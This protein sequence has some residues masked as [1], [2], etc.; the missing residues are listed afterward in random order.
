MRHNA[1]ASNQRLMSSESLVEADL[2]VKAIL[3]LEGSFGFRPAGTSRLF[4]NEFPHDRAIG[5]FR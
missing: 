3:A 1:L 4:A 5:S 2:S